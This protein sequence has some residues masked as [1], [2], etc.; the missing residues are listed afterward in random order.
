MKNN[1]QITVEKDAYE[2]CIQATLPLLNE[3]QRRLFLANQSQMLGRGGITLLSNITGID[4]NT[5]TAGVK[6][7][8]E[9]QETDP[10]TA[11]H[12]KIRN[13]PGSTVEG[14]QRVREP[15]AGRKAIEEKQPGIV[16]ALLEI[17]RK[18]NN[19]GD[20]EGH[21]LEW[22][23]QSTRNMAD[24]LVEKGY[25]I[26]HTMVSRLLREQGYSLQENRKMKQVGKSH[27][28]RDAQFKNIDSTATTYMACGNPVISIDCKKKENIGEFKND[29]QTYQEKGKPVL[30]LD[31]D[32]P[33]PE[34]GK[35]APYGIYDIGK[36][37]GFVN[38]GIS[39][40]TAQFA[41]ESIRRW[42][43]E[44]GKENYPNA[45][46]LYITADGGGSNGS[47]CRLWKVELSKLCT[48]IGIPIEVSH[49]PP[50]TSK[51]NKIEHRMF[52]YITKNWRGQPLV[53][54]AV[55]VSLISATKTKSGLKIRCMPDGTHY[56][57][58]IKVRD[59][60]LQGLNIVYDDFHPEWNYTLFPDAK[61]TD[62]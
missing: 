10:G 8:R 30:V 60:E 37:Q 52:S 5:I 11:N 54:M 29:G 31:H 48:E 13:I 44:M 33:L 4:R 39:A 20:P 51:W 17:V 2:A 19:Y 47:R 15:G 18:S 16:E 62:N 42:W 1:T 35:A 12:M 28:D 23:S 22:V 41:V 36:N 14:K 24:K 61:K 45:T 27:P 49:F 9:S 56:A 25:Q 34:N 43:N 6:E 59:E 46:A 53:T 50:G 38:V 7:L 40:D 57:R 58:G 3:R 26:S 32:F 21:V 55:I